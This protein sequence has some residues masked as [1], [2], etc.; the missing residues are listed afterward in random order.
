MK[1]YNNPNYEELEQIFENEVKEMEK[2]NGIIFRKTVATAN[3]QAALHTRKP[4][5][6][7]EVKYDLLPN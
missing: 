3:L 6:T 7:I 5:N 4:N 1:N 2:Q